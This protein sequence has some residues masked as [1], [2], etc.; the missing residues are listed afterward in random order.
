MKVQKLYET[1]LINDEKIDK[2]TDQKPFLALQKL[3]LSNIVTYHNMEL[4]DLIDDTE[5]ED[6][7]PDI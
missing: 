5:Y 6:G 3:Q 4:E 7:L 1:G 2:R